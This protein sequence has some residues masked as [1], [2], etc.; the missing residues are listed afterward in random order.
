MIY[1]INKFKINY[2]KNKDYLIQFTSKNKK[3]EEFTLFT[4]R[5]LLDNN[6][7]EVNYVKN[8]FIVNTFIFENIPK[9]DL[10]IIESNNFLLIQEIPKSYHSKKKK[11]NESAFH[12]N[13]INEKYLK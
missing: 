11:S 4:F 9:N 12:Y 3:I 2:N 13:A 7:I 1:K 5:V 8:D 10:S 6:K